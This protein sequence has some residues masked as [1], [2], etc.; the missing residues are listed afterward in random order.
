[1]RNKTLVNLADDGS[2]LLPHGMD[3][4]PH[5]CMRT[6]DDMTN[7]GQS[8]AFI[9]GYTG[10]KASAFTGPDTSPRFKPNDDMDATPRTKTCLREAATK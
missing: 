7:L 3:I 4:A 1:M 2:D 10:G 8:G 9:Y 5:S 6:T